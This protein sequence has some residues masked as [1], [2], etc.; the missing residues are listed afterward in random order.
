MTVAGVDEPD[1]MQALQ[2]VFGESLICEVV[3]CASD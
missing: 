3:R 1:L 2:F